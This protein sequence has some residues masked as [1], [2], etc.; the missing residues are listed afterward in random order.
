MNTISRKNWYN[1]FLFDYQSQAMSD[2]V[3]TLGWVTV[4]KPC[5]VGFL[6]LFS[7]IFYAYLLIFIISGII[8]VHNFSLILV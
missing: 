6:F 3:S 1:T 5:V 4:W 8:S 7:H 2:T